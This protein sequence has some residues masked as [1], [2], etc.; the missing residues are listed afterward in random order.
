MARTDL[1]KMIKSDCEDGLAVREV[2][3]KGRGVFSTKPFARG[4]FVCEY[5]GDLIKLSKAKELEK[6]YSR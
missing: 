1:E 5:K 2:E 4:S 6:T 3:G